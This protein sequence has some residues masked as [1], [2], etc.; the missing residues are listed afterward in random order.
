MKNGKYS[1]RRG[2]ASKTLVLALA[3]M[4]I[5][6]ASIGGTIAWL[7]A[8]T[9]EVVNTFTIGDINI[10]LYEHAYDA[11][12]NELSSTETTKAVDN[13]K[14]VPGRN[15]P[16]DP[17][18]E[19]KANSEACWLFVKVTKTNWPNNGKVSY[20]IANG[21]TPL[22][23]EDGVYYREVGATGNTSQTFKVLAND[24]VT[25]SGE[26]TKS[27]LEAIKTAGTPTLTFKAY[28][29]QKENLTFTQ[30]WD[31]VNSRTV[32]PTT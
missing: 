32:T 25:V 9:N 21:W 31:A 3:V 10:D 15:L 24:Q 13:Y 18:V 27:E 14:L 22:A 19:V 28:A 17:T 1:K 23:G 20:A 7:T 8:E 11:T 26:L 5:V 30:A 2:V 16:K 4:L 6:G 29:A 12:K